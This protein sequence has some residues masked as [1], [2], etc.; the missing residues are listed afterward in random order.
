MG[1]GVLPASFHCQPHRYGEF[2]RPRRGAPIY[3]SFSGRLADTAPQRL[4]QEAQLVGIG[5][6]P[7]RHRAA[8]AVAGVR[9][10]AQQRWQA[11]GGGRLQGGGDT[12][13]DCIGDR[14]SVPK[15]FSC[16]DMRRGQSLVVWAIRE[17][18]QCAR[19]V[20]AFLMGETSLPR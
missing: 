11:Q 20:D 3:P 4:E 1:F 18:R 8:D 13:S 10:C 14:T 15:I 16:G 12:G 5:F 17:G 6:D 9:V 7:G 2:S 19:S